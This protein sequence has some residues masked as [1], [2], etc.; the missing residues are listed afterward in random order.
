VASATACESGHEA[1]SAAATVRHAG[2][3]ALLVALLVAF[4]ALAGAE[5]HGL[6]LFWVYGCLGLVVAGVGSVDSVVV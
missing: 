1:S 2:V 4:V 3:D 6:S 5:A